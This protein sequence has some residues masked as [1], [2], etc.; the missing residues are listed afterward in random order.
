MIESE[1]YMREEEVTEEKKSDSGIAVGGCVR[2]CEVRRRSKARHVCS[3]LCVL[4][5]LE[6]VTLFFYHNCTTSGVVLIF[7]FSFL[8]IKSFGRANPN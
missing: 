5:T 6:I 1:G 2:V 4:A 7:N 3:A 8:L